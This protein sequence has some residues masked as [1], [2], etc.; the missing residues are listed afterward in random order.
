MESNGI[1][2]IIKQLEQKRTSQE[3]SL[4]DLYLQDDGC[5]RVC[6]HMVLFP[7]LTTLDLRGNS[8][9]EIGTQ[10]IATL[11]KTNKNIKKYNSFCF[12][13]WFYIL[14]MYL[15]FNYTHVFFWT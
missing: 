10:A 2:E 11:I 6:R 12:F 9:H 4:C 13:P 14:Y 7:N 1:D 3:I 15:K 5:D 8:I